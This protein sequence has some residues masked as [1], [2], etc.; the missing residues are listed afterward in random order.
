MGKIINLKSPTDFSGFYVIYK[1]SV[2]NE[3][4]KNFGISHL[5]EH[6]MCKSFEKLYDDFDRYG[7]NWNAYTSS[8]EI[9]YHIT[10]LDE[11][12]YKYRHE[13]VNMLLDFNIPKKEFETERD[14]VIQ[15]YRDTFQDQGTSHYYNILRKELGNYGPIGKIESLES[16]T[17]DDIR[18]YFNDYLSK[19]SLI[20]NVS[21]NNKFEGFDVLSDKK[22][23]KYKRVEDEK[24]LKIEKMADFKKSS[25]IGY[26]LVDDDFAYIKFISMML[27]GSMKSPLMD[28]IRKKR[29]LTYGVS[30]SVYGYS[31]ENG[32]LSTE[33]ITDDDKVDEVLKTYK[34]V[35]SNPDKYLTKDRFDLIKDYYKVQFKKNEINRYNSIRHLITPDNWDLEK[36]INDITY[37]QIRKIYDKYFLFDKLKWSIDKKDF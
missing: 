22:Y 2:M 14:V 24:D 10:G 20:I 37:D 15:E 34:M 21:K 16:L 12:I 11:Y 8:T 1:G 9:V 36:I 26:K 18:K 4:Q 7:I 19:P 17:Y 32:L 23:N 29:G 33:L 35:L 5:M 30:T 27:S 6:L 3:E 13:L 31:Y 25:V 28:E